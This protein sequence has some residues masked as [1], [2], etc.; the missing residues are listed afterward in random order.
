MEEIKTNVLVIGK[1]GVGKSSLL[2]Y[3]FNETV[4]KTGTGKPVTEKGIFPFDYSYDDNLK[5][6]IYDTWGLEPNKAEEWK[7]LIKDEVEKHD[8]RDIK[9]WF[10]TIIFCI[11]ANSDRVE[12][13]EIE[14]MKQLLDMNN[15]MVI[16]ITHCNSAEDRRG[17]TLRHQIVALTGLREEQVVFVSSVN[18][19]LIGKKVEK[20]GRKNVFVMIIKNLWNS[21]K[22]KVPYNIR[23]QT[24]EELNI[25]KKSLY[26][27]ISK[28]RMLFQR[29]KKLTTF[30]KEVNK[31]FGEFLENIIDRI[32]NRFIDAINYYNAL[33]LKYAEVALIDKEKVI[34]MPDMKFDFENEIKKEVED[35]LSTIRANK[36][37]ISTLMNSDITRE[38]IQELCVVLKK[39]LSSAQEIKIELMRTVDKYIERVERVIEKQIDN[40]Q[41]QLENIDVEEIGKSMFLEDRQSD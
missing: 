31:E 22:Q 13:F 30:E 32:N 14:I 16:A 8:K 36:N 15:Q 2:N 1:S 10:N 33:S 3:M 11:S 23:R 4:Q 26:E 20:F 29:D 37:K 9:D 7:E 28:Q 5:I 38:V 39:Y 19:E 34:N 25:E 27:K 12:D 17:I 18:K 21:L 6:C 40:I 24:K 41:K 35:S